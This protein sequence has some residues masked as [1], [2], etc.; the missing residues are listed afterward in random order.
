[1]NTND[2]VMNPDKA[3][4]PDGFVPH[5]VEEIG[6]GTATAIDPA[7][8]QKGLVPVPTMSQ[9]GVSGQERE[10]DNPE[11]F[12]K[13]IKFEGEKEFVHYVR[14]NARGDV[15]DPWGLFSD[16]TQNSRIASHKGVPQY[17]FR[18]VSERAFM[19]YLRYLVT[20]NGSLLR[21]CE[22]DIKDA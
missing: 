13:S 9:T 14:M 19:N 3:Q 16:S 10:T 2:F 15:S 12:A 5:I 7:T 17:E 6:Y 11:C 22:R 8:K 21:I 1:M 4:A 20:R 18:R